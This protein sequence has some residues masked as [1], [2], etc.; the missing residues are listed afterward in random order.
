MTK[1]RPQQNPQNPPQQDPINADR[2][3]MTWRF[4][5]RHNQL[6]AERP[7]QLYVVAQREGQWVLNVFSGSDE[8]GWVR[9]VTEVDFP[10]MTATMTRAEDWAERA[11]WYEQ[12]MASRQDWLQW[13]AE[14]LRQMVEG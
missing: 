2:Y 10:D 9:E 6:E 7:G 11:E 13:Q 3:G 14:A 5:F 4:N 1:K 8:I 12:E